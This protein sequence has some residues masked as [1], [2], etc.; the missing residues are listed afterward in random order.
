MSE[1]CVTYQCCSETCLWAGKSQKSKYLFLQTARWL[2]AKW[3]L[4]LRMLRCC[5]L[6]VE[7]SNN[8]NML[9]SVQRSTGQKR[10]FYWNSKFWNSIENFDCKK[11]VDS[12]DRNLWNWM[13]KISMQKKTKIQRSDFAN[14]IIENSNLKKRTHF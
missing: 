8:S 9:K 13:S 5:T 12:P 14:M 3:V 7:N 2:I 10:S 11:K 4:W 6:Y 1:Q